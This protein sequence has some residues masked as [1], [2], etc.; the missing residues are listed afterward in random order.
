[1]N[2][3]KYDLTTDIYIKPYSTYTYKSTLQQ[4]NCILELM[5]DEEYFRIL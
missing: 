1:M 2:V 5:K 4:N 3:E